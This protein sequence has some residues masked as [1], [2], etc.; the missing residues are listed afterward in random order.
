MNQSYATHIR[1]FAAFAF[2]LTLST[3]VKAIAEIPQIYVDSIYY[4]I[5]TLKLEATVTHEVSSS[6]NPAY[7]S[8][9]PN[10]IIIPDTISYQG[11]EY[12]VTAIDSYAFFNCTS[13]QSVTIPATV[14]YIYSRALGGCTALKK[15]I[16]EDSDSKIS[17]TTEKTSATGIDQKPFNL[18]NLEEVYIGRN[19]AYNKLPY[20]NV[21]EFPDNV[22]SYDYSMFYGATK[23]ANVTIGPKCTKILDYLFYNLPNLTLIS[24]PNVKDIGSYAFQGCS[25]LASVKFNEGLDSIGI[26]AFANC[27]AITRLSLPESL[28]KI[29]NNAFASC[30]SI[31]E[32]SIGNSLKEIGRAGFQ[33]CTSLTAIILPNKFSTMGEYAFDGC[34]RL[35][36]AQL[37][38]SITTIPAYAFRNCTSLAD[39]IFPASVTSVGNYAFYNDYGIALCRLNEGLK[40]IGASVFY[41]CS[42]LSRMEI[43]GTVTYMGE[44]SFTRCSSLT[45]LIFKY[46]EEE[47]RINTGD[48]SH[49]YFQSCPIRFLTL[50]RNITYN[51]STTGAYPSGNEANT[52]ASG[53]FT[54]M[55]SIINVTLGDNVTFLY[56]NLFNGCTG[57]KKL[58]LPP[59]LKK[60]YL[61]AL[62]NCSGLQELV[63]PK[64][65]ELLDNYACYGD[66]ALVSV[67]FEEAE[68]EELEMPIGRQTFMNCISLKSITIPGK[69]TEI[70]RKCF[71]NARSLKE[72]TFRDSKKPISLNNVESNPLFKDCPL[73]RLYIGRNINY[74]ITN[75]NISPFSKQTG[76]TDVEF[77]LAGTVTSCGEYFL[78]GASACDSLYLPESITEL[79]KCA[80]AD[81][82]SLKHVNIPKGVKVLC[83]S[84]F[85]NDGLISSIAIPGATTTIEKY[86]F[87]KCV[88]LRDVSFEDSAAPISVGYGLSKSKHYSLFGYSPLRKLYI[89]RDIYYTPPTMATGGYSPFYGQTELSDVTFSQNGTVT[90]CG[91]NLLNGA[92][93]CTELK[94]P[95]SLTTIGASAFYDMISLENIVIPD[96]VT[97][98]GRY[99]FANDSTMTSVILSKSCPVIDEGVFLECKSI[100]EIIIPQVVD[101]IKDIAFSGCKSLSTVIFNDGKKLVSTGKGSNDN[102][103]TFYGCPVETLHVGRQ[104]SYLRSPFNN[105]PELKNLT[106]GP[107]VPL[108]GVNMFQNTGLEEVYLPDNIESI[109]KYGF[110]NCQLLRSVR[111]GNETYQVGD[112]GFSR[113]V[114]L[115][116][117]SFP[118]S[119]SSIADNSFSFCTSL[120]NLDLGKSL[121][122]IGPAAFQNDSLISHIEI[123]ETLY[124]LGV[125]AFAGC[126]SLPY[127]EVRGVSSVGKQ[128]FQGCTGLKWISLSDKTTSLGENSFNECSGIEYVKSYA[129][130]P[131]EGLVNFPEE[132]VANGT[133]YV[134]EFSV[135]YYKY[136]PTWENWFDIRP[137]GEFSGIGSVTDDN[138]FDITINGNNVDLTN[139]PDNAHCVIYDFKGQIIKSFTATG[140]YSGHITLAPGFYIISVN[141]NARK[142]MI[143]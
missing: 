111:F 84:L 109:G 33:N 68:N 49:Y 87:D 37:S 86:V 5:D 27:A 61:C 9:L 116:N 132:V 114:S 69:A 54:Q 140:N 83:E 11:K 62:A 80:F 56:H 28:Q 63:F 31:T 52:N 19:I 48:Y 130:Y 103:G 74:S 117:V 133:L 70:G 36:V 127:V 43:P 30:S 143:R 113:C 66:S 106:F 81:M 64:S 6:S 23:L 22:A 4:T 141:S 45:Y 39:I 115:D 138:T 135:D 24:M 50:N 34:S 1:R 42:G 137:I 8:P 139:L 90:Y 38:D 75:Y 102:Y 92:I 73:T 110:Y 134:P 41:G 3:A 2:L 122:I 40:T 59:N 14:N 17:I 55:S 123:P 98:V 78:Q 12:T 25:K 89:G 101:S 118:E 32:V 16:F 72:L 53:P 95:E 126:V 46:G 131:P 97:K 58:T 44:S 136:S 112:Y 57:I 47:L 85:S 125:S 18:S 93:S 26:N 35:T 105:I 15:L 65:L 71:K 76:L 107:D 128:A 91:D 108:V 104:V 121:K 99:A 88:S 10:H 20:S 21:G 29:G 129:E 13:I 94:L 77:S 142:I 100:S 119:M 79:G 124:G 96:K 67:T 60:I 7:Y 120:K 82:T 51:S